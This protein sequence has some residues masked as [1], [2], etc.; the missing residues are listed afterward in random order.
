M[1]QRFREWD[2]YFVDRIAN[3]TE[4]LNDN[5]L[6]IPTEREVSVL[7]RGLPVYRCV[8]TRTDTPFVPTTLPEPENDQEKTMPPD[9][10]E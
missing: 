2:T 10:E 7:E 4:Y 1:R 8:F 3:P 9:D 6:Q 5:I